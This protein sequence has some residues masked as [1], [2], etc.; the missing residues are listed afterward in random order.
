MLFDCYPEIISMTDMV[1]E[2]TWAVNFHCNSHHELLHIIAGR[3][4]LTLTDGSV[5]NASPGDTLIIPAQTQHRDVFDFSEDLEIFLIHFDWRQWEQ[6]HRTVTLKE[7]GYLEDG[8]KRDLKHLFDRMRF[9]TGHSEL[10]REIANSRLMTI[11]LL[12][13]RGVAN[14]NDPQIKVED[15]SGKK[16]RQRLVTEAK[17]YIDKHYSEPVQLMDI[18]AYLHVSPFYL[19]RIFARESDFS[20]V[21]YLTEVRM[22]A[23]KQLLTDGRYIVAD[24]AEM[25]GYQD[26]N[27]FSKVFR[28]H[29]GCAPSKYR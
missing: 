16:R 18:A 7:I 28:K 15:L 4:K 26:S 6:Y 25:V 10:D 19:S 20:L 5:F 21:E 27:Y 9:D 29:V 13:Y 14:R 23:A 2:T 11:L 1:F 17:R 24:I 22:N 8:L 3:L 12:I